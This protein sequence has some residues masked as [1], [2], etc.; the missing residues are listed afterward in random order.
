[1]HHFQQAP[2][3]NSPSGSAPHPQ[4]NVNPS[5]LRQGNMQSNMPPLPPPA[6]SNYG[7]FQQPSQIPTVAQ[8]WF[9]NNN[10][11]APQASHPATIPQPPP[12]PQAERTPPIKADQWDEIYLGVLHTQDAAKLRELLSHTNPELIMP[13]NGAPLV[14]QAVILTLVHRV[15]YLHYSFPAPFLTIHVSALCYCRRNDDGN[16]GVI[17]DVSLVASAFCSFPS[18][19]GSSTLSRVFNPCR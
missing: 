13:T 6:P 18:A 4:S 7:S 16:R 8:G 2:P 9:S 11:A 10:I 1:M 14:S 19:R 12:P 5:H 17:Q 3:H 15:G